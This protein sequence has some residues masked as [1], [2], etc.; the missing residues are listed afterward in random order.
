LGLRQLDATASF[1]GKPIR[2]TMLLAGS[3]NTLALVRI[4]SNADDTSKHQ[5]LV[6]SV[7]DAIK[8]GP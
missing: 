5:S 2:V 8:V 7:L 1:S 4:S 3:G 6:A